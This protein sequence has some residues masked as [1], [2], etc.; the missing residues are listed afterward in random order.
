MLNNAG[1]RLRVPGQAALKLRLCAMSNVSASTAV[2]VVLDVNVDRILEVAAELLRLLLRQ[3]IASNH[4]RASRQQNINAATRRAARQTFERL[5]HVD[6]LLGARLEVRDT[7][8][9]LAE[10]VRPLSGDLARV[11]R[12]RP[13]RTRGGEGGMHTTRLLSSTSILLPST[14][15]M[16]GYHDG[17]RGLSRGSLTKGK[18]S[19]SLGEAWIKNSSRQLS[20]ASKLLELLTSN[21]STQQ[22]APR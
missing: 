2:P 18:L 6:G 22:S 13:Q 11:S 20:R 21:T 16:D 12:G 10:G 3:G 14:T 1:T 7:P 15:W 5:F 8:F 17:P 9:G 4:Y 19:G